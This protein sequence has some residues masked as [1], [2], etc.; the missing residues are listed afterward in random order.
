MDIIKKLGG[1]DSVF[2]ILKSSDWPYAES[3]LRMQISRGSLSKD[4]VIIL[5]TYMNDNH[6]PY[7]INDFYANDEKE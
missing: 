1:F 4:V 6:I 5:V 3:A 2:G 7:Q